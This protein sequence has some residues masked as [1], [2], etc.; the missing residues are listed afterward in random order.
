MSRYIVSISGM[1]CMHCAKSVKKALSTLDGVE[2]VEVDL[3]KGTAK[4]V[5]DGPVAASE[6]IDAIEDIGYEFVSM[7]EMA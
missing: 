1:H 4:I 2:R 5:A 3:K 6:V 7:E